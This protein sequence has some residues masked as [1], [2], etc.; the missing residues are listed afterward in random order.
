MVFPYFSRMVAEK[1]WTNVRSTLR[2]YSRLILALSVPATI[3]IWFLSGWIVS[4][5]FERGAFNS[6]DAA[7]V[8][9]VQQILALM[10]PFYA[11]GVLYSRAVVSLQKTH[12]M[13]ISSG[14]VFIV[15]VVADYLLKELIGVNGIALATVIN[16]ALQFTLMWFLTRRA[17]A[18]RTQT[19]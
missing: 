2:L 3:A 16:Y 7:A 8:A 13:L 1:H 18:E 15:N 14:I 5:L 4:L 11:L 12:L 6:S 17:L 9:D 19:G 10:I